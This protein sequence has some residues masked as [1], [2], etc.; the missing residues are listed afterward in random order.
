MKPENLHL[1]LA[2]LG[3]TPDPS[4]GEV[5]AAAAQA[6]ASVA[7]FNLAFTGAGRF[8]QRGRIRV[9][10]LAVIDGAPSLLELGAGASARPRAPL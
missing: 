3:Q 10:W 9:V 5:T 8:P 7:P 6:A 4:L 2:F 1:T